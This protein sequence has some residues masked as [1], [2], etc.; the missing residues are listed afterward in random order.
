MKKRLI[1]LLWAAACVIG[2]GSGAQAAVVLD[3]EDAFG[4]LDSGNGSDGI[5]GGLTWSQFFGVDS[6]SANSHAQ[7]YGT[8]WANVTPGGDYY[9]YNGWGY[10]VSVSREDAFTF[11]GGYFL[12]GGRYDTPRTEDLNII[13]WLDGIE[14]YSET[15]AIPA[16]T[17]TPEWFELN[18]TNVDTVTFSGADYNIGF[19]LDEFTYT[20]VP[21]PGAALLLAS[22]L[23]GLAAAR[24]S[25]AVEGP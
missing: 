14:V 19:C 16:G 25:G 2:M 4:V 10:A 17:C 7:E 1:V 8:A 6:E 21:L 13:G 9:A 5:Y 20:S 3:F 18:Y 22:G 15:I 24:R 12:A 11:V 23:I